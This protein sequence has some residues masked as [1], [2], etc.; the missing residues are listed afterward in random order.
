MGSKDILAG[1]I[2]GLRKKNNHTQEDLGKLLNV[3]KMTVSGWETQRK[4]PSFEM[5][6]KIAEIYHV[7]VSSLFSNGDE[8]IHS[9]VAD[10]QAEVFRCICALA[11]SRYFSRADLEEHPAS[12]S[13]AGYQKEA[14]QTLVFTLSNWACYGFR[15]GTPSMFQQRCKAAVSLAEV[16]KTGAMSNSI[17]ASAVNGIV[18]SISEKDQP[19]GTDTEAI[20]D[21]ELPF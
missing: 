14:V 12:V 3:D 1:N 9:A 2:R 17:Y 11:A 5:L 4:E 10:T 13:P 18:A 16:L 19:T 21:D 15:N 8:S 6:D 7:S 20:G